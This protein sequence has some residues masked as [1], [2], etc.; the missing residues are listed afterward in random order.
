MSRP[1]RRALLA[2]LIAA[3]LPFAA[4]AQVPAGYPASYQSI[5]DAAKK[6]GKVIVYNKRL[7]QPN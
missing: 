7:L 2:G 1:T 6:E 5:V 4:S 3:A